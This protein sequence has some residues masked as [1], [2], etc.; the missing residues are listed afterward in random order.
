MNRKG[1][2]GRVREYMEEFALR[3]GLDPAGSP[4]R[5]YLW[6]DA[7]AVCNYLDLFRK[8]GNGTHRELALSPC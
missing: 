8:T 4:P 2:D 5:R 3:T 7:F 6:T 1:T